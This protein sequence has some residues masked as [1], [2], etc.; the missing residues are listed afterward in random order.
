MV[1]GGHDLEN[2][3]KRAAHMRGINLQQAR[4]TIEAM[5]A[6]IGD[7]REL[8]R[9][10]QSR[11]LQQQ[12]ELALQ[13]ML[14]FTQFQPKLIGALVHGDGPLDAIRL[15]LFADTAEQVIVHLSDRHIPWQEAEVTLHYSGGRRVGRPALRFRAGEAS[16][17][18]IVLGLR[19]HSDPP[20]DPIT[21]G[22]LETLSVDEL[23]ALIDQS[24]A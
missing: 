17:E 8:F 9:P 14:A 22:R 4:P 24:P 16:I 15:L 5:R 10:Q 21:G 6:A 19:S 1:D 2:A 18:L 12:R 13:A 20:R 23:N 3:L 11:L 7:Y